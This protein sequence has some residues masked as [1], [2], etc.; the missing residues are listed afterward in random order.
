LLPTR[1][2]YAAHDDGRDLAV[3]DVTNPAFAVTVTDAELAA[4][5]DR[6]LV[7]LAQQA[8]MAPAVHAALQQSELGR[9]I[10]AASDGFLGCLPTYLLKL[11]PE[12]LGAWETSPIDRHIAASFPALALRMRVQ[13]MAR[14]LADGLAGVVAAEPRRRVCLVNI[15]GGLAADS[16]NALLLLHTEQPELLDRRAVMIAVLD[17]D[18]QGPAFAAR[19]VAAL[20]GP[21]APLSGLDIRLEHFQYEWSDTER[22]R[23]LL[24]DLHAADAAC[25]ISSEGG[26]F[27]YG[28]DAEIVANLGVLQ[29]CT[30]P[31]AVVVGSVTRDG[32]LMR[33]AQILHRI[34]IRPRTIE[35]F[36]GLVE[37]AG[38][39]VEQVIE[40][41]LSYHVLLAKGR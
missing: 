34:S 2:L 17:R 33:A 21:G 1:I 4:M 27:E 15:A 11:G 38:W 25:A 10:A 29:A 22:L 19:A 40:R 16:W 3:I 26:L 12:N 32:A 41:P 24:G 31:D 35:A 18:E 9:A 6:H 36:R 8:Q 28:S 39:R 5:T 14:L 7:E 20:C 23:Q 37:E 13:D 30:A